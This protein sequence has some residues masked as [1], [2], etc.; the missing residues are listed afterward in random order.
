[1]RNLFIYASSNSASE[2]M[3]SRRFL[4]HVVVS[5][6]SSVGVARDLLLMLWCVVPKSWLSRAVEVTRYAHRLINLARDVACGVVRADG[7][8]SHARHRV[9]NAVYSDTAEHL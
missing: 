3:C 1:M 5:T 4:A 9:A 6:V 8:M 7:V 2:R